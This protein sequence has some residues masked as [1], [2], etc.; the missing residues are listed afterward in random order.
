MFERMQ[1]FLKHLKFFKT[2]RRYSHTTQ[3]EALRP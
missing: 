2:R 1:F 3:V